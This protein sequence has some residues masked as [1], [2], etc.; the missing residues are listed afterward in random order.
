MLSAL[1]VADKEALQIRP[2]DGENQTRIGAELS[3]AQRQRG[4]EARAR[5]RSPRAASAPGK[6]TTGLMLLISA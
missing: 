3:G 1:L 4:D 2:V 6:R 5:S